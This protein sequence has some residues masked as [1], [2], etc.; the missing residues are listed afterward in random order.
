M[1]IRSVATVTS[2]VCLGVKN[3][4][5]NLLKIINLKKFWRVTY[6]LYKCW[7]PSPH[8]FKDLHRETF[9]M[10]FTSYHSQL[11]TLFLGLVQLLQQ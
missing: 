3:F 10:I 5:H 8:Y 6:I 7:H 2:A 11:S 1:L 4:S 9:V